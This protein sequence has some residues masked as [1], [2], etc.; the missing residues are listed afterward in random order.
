[1]KEAVDKVRAAYLVRGKN[2]KDVVQS[3]AAR[4]LVEC[5]GLKADPRGKASQQTDADQSVRCWKGLTT[6]LLKEKICL[7]LL[8]NIDKSIS[9]NAPRVEERRL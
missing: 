9:K 5:N 4:Q 8:L 7:F 1:M 2:G 6:V 3:S